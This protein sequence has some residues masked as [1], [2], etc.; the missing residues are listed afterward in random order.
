[1][2]DGG[3]DIAPEGVVGREGI[4]EHFGGQL[5]VLGLDCFLFSDVIGVLLTGLDEKEFPE[6]VLGLEGK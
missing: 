2:F 6:G 3:G 1:M 4:L 5:G